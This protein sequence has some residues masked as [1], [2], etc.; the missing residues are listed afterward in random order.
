MEESLVENFI[1]L[2]K[3]SKIEKQRAD[4]SSCDQS[5]GAKL[6]C[7]IR[8]DELL[9]GVQE[10]TDGSNIERKRIA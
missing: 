5:S 3:G 10:P 9:Q 2:T 4:V 6:T 8:L 1:C 7:I